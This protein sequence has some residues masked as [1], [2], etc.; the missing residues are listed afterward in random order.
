MRFVLLGIFGLFC[1]TKINK[2]MFNEA[3][4]E[5]YLAKTPKVGPVLIFYSSDKT[6]K[7][8]NLPSGMRFILLAI[9]GLSFL[10]KI[11]KKE[12]TGARP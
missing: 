1:M 9:I 5:K 7:Y 4:L 8:G 6:S 10:A 2:K 11:N 12:F 3:R